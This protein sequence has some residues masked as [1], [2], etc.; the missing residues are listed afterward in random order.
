VQ[1]EQQGVK[2]FQLH[3]AMETLRRTT[4]STVALRPATR[5]AQSPSK[6]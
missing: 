3:Y 5:T 4:K 6:Q 2:D 1:L